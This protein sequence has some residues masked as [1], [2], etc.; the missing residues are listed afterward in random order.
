[1]V[2]KGADVNGID[3]TLGTPLML[4]IRD[5]VED[6]STA[7]WLVESMGADVT[8]ITPQ[9]TALN[10][11]C[12]YGDAALI[13]FLIAHGADKILNLPSPK[14][15]TPLALA[16]SKRRNEIVS[17]LVK[18]HK[19]SVLEPDALFLACQN[20]HV[21]TVQLLCELGADPNVLQP[22]MKCYPLHLVAS[23]NFTMIA[24]ILLKHGATVDCQDP[25]GYTP[26]FMAASE[27]YTKCISRLIAAGANV[28][29][30]SSEDYTTAI[31]HAV[32]ANRFSV[33][34]VLLQAGADPLTT[35]N[36]KK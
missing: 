14:L 22:K 24:D 12:E 10:N 35:R 17:H 21:D 20:D 1:L 19:A 7:R 30:R 32:N 11:A 31:F 28:N 23:N 29:H 9:G 5:G 27:G 6:F 16:A 33:V 15:T 25:R 8:V 34:Q 4:A 13:D 36:E 18:K 3:P 2:Q 26:L